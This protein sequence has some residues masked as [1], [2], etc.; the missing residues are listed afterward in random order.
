LWYV[1]VIPIGAG[2]NWERWK[3]KGREALI[4]GA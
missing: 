4:Y 3:H 2:S 1:K